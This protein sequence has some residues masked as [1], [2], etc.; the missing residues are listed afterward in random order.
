MGEAGDMGY[1]LIAAIGVILAVFVVY[2]I[3]SYRIE[4]EAKRDSV[5]KSRAR[6]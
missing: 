6:Q 4:A 2:V 3:A 1:I 5:V